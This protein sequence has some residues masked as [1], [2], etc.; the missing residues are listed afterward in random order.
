M[1]NIR[2]HIEYDGLDFLGWQRQPDGPTIQAQLED[3]LEKVLGRKTIVYGSSRTDSGVHARGQVAN[4]YVDESVAIGPE[5]WCHVLNFNLPRTIRVWHSSEAPSSF[6]SQKRVS[7]K[8]YEYRLL[9]RPV[10]S[11]LDRSTLFYP[12]PLNW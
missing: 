3:C 12:R 7:S 1:R 2:L 4:F 10:A 5:R 11:A 6:H 9:S 8:V